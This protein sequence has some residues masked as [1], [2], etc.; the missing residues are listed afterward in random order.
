M[1][2]KVD[3][4]RFPH[5]VQIYKEDIDPITGDPVYNVVFESE[6]GY[7][8][9]DRV[10][11]IETDSLRSFYKLSIPLNDYPINKLDNVIFYHNYTKQII[12]GKVVEY[13]PYNLGCEILMQSN[14]NG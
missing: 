14:G 3:N 5:K 6:C 8:K 12:K 13:N 10:V 9:M 1:V 2:S 11:N 7:R 4:P